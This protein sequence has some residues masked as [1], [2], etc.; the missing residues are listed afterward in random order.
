MKVQKFIGELQFSSDH[1]ASCWSLQRGFQCIKICGTWNLYAEVIKAQNSI[2]R[3]HLP[4]VSFHGSSALLH[5]Q[6][7][8]CCLVL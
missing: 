5:A 1:G 7:S 3:L 4:F 8:P 6:Y 2:D